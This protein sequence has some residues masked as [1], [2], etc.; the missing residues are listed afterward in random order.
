MEVNKVTNNII[1]F[2]FD[3]GCS[4]G[5][6][7]K[8]V[9]A[10]LFKDNCLELFR[11]V[12]NGDFVHNMDLEQEFEVLLCKLTITIDKWRKADGLF[13]KSKER[14][15]IKE[16]DTLMTMVFRKYFRLLYCIVFIIKGYYN[17]FFFFF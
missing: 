1:K 12:K 16:I 15:S 4:K 6:F 14:R 10:L 9:Y 8:I 2:Y 7:Q 11:H 5:E 13:K 3:Y 17:P